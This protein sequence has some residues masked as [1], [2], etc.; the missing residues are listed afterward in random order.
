MASF[1]KFGFEPSYTLP[2][3]SLASSKLHDKLDHG[4]L[5]GID[6]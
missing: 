6:G 1:A 5:D 3:E 4:L 2:V